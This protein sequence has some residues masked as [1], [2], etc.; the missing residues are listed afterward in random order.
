FRSKL[1][2][3]DPLH[4]P[5]P[6]NKDGDTPGM[7]TDLRKIYIEEERRLA[8]LRAR[9]QD[10]HPLVQQQTSKVNLVLRELK[11][12]VE[13]AQTAANI[14]YNETLRDEQKVMAQMEE[15]K[16]EGLR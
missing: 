8:E 2:E 11:R 10:D 9:Y 5:P 1:K 15:V 3:A 12:E 6:N 16:Q 4:V 7:L 14:R 13:M